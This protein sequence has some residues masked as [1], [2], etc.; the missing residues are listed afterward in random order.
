ML[1]SGVDRQGNV[2]L[3]LQLCL[4]INYIVLDLCGFKITRHSISSNYDLLY[5]ENQVTICLAHSEAL[6]VSD[7]RCMFLLPILFEG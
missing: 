2:Q 7:Q 4:C 1:K 5:F 6:S 3:L